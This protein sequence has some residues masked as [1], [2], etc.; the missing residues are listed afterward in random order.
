[1]RA[2]P[3]TGIGIADTGASS[4]L[5]ALGALGMMGLSVGSRLERRVSPITRR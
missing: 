1:V 2:L 5:L 4:L 3:K